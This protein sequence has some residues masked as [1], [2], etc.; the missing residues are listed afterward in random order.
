MRDPVQALGAIFRERYEIREALGE[1]GFGT[2]YKAVQL[3]TG[4]AVAIKVLRLPEG[5]AP[6]GIEKRVA[7]FQRE[8]QICAQMRHPNI[9]GLIDSGQAEGGIVYSIF[10]YLPGQN[11]AELLVKEGRLEPVEARHFMV[12][13]LDALACAHGAGVVHRDLKP[14]NIMIISTGARRNAVVLDFG[15]SALTEEAQRDEGA[16]LTMTNECIGTP[17]Y[18]APEQLRGHPPTPRTDLY[19]WGLVFLECLTGRRVFDGHAFA[20]V[21]FKQLSPDPIPVPSAIADHALGRILRRVTAKDAAARDATA[22]TLLRE[23]EG[24]D[25]SGLHLPPEI[26]LLERASPH[27]TTVTLHQPTPSVPPTL[28]LVDVERGTTPAQPPAALCPVPARPTPDKVISGNAG[29]A[30][31]A[32]TV[33]VAAVRPPAVA[34]PPAVARVVLQRS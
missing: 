8:M 25:L 31:V 26:P 7:R 4:Q 18:A 19:A 20:E 13:V 24:C 11:L 21:V 6:Q 14:A 2:V 9:V 17:A 29:N 3:A 33:L 30:G 5:G 28:T 1:G 32:P 16:R 27:A 23:V 22:D 10:E 15:I 12:Q 34:E